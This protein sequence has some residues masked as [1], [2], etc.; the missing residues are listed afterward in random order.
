MGVDQAGRHGAAH[1]ID[2]ARVLGG[3][4]PRRGVR[5]D[6]DDFSAGDCDGLR[7][8][9][10]GV[11]CEDLSVDEKEITGRGRRNLGPGRDGHEW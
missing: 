2:D 6:R 3:G 10:A 9:I 7:H 5:S 8:R 4:L 1:E 11:H